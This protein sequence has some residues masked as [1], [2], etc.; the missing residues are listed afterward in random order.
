ME[1]DAALVR[2]VLNGQTEAYAELVRRHER[3]LLAT[4][5]AVLGE[6]HAAQDAAQESLVIA[7]ERLGSLRDGNAF[8]PWTI[9][10]AERVA[11]GMRRRRGRIKP[12]N[13]DVEKASPSQNHP[14]DDEIQRLFQAVL[15][16]P[17]KQRQAVL[18]RYFSGHSIDTISAITTQP[19]G[20]VRSHLSRGLARLR[21][22]LKDV[23]S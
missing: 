7:Y 20:T 10:I 23:E 11:L 5:G 15:K 6:L 2:R 9:R 1:D 8:G 16:L 14:L 18:L 22:G 3:A 19:A 13:E 12:L 4:A 17:E 21:A